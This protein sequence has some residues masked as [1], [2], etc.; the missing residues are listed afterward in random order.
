MNQMAGGRQMMA[1]DCCEHILKVLEELPSLHIT[2]IDSKHEARI[3]TI[4]GEIHLI[5]IGVSQY[6]VRRLFISQLR[7][8]Y[9]DV[10]ILILRREEG[11]QPEVEDRVRG[12][13]ILS[14]TSHLDDLEIV[15]SLR[16]VLPFKPCEHI[17]RGENFDTVREVVRVIAE[18]YSDPDLDLARVAKEV[19]MSPVHLSKILNQ[20]VGVSFRKLLRQV[21][22]EE[23]KRML[24][25]RRYSVKQVASQVGFSDT[26]YF[27]RSFRELT[28]LSASE[29]RAKDNLFG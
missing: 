22:I 9:P 24:A 17:H 4:E 8:I 29:F 18:K 16:A 11:I 6:P 15:R 20:Q 12:E 27:S 14:D 2:S 25:T 23:A 19:P 7:R 3:N 28:G 21:R 10:P 13:F 5:V 26:H 1:V